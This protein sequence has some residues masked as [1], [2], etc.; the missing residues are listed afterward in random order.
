MK[1]VQRHHQQCHTTNYG[2]VT[3]APVQQNATQQQDMDDLEEC[4][5][6][7]QATLL[8]SILPSNETQGSNGFDGDMDDDFDYQPICSTV[9]PPSEDEG[10][11]V[12]PSTFD[13][14]EVIPFE[15]NDLHYQTGPTVVEPQIPVDEF[16]KHMLL[17][18]AVAAASVLV[19]QAAFQSTMPSTT[20]LPLPNIMLFLYL[21]KLVLSTGRLELSNL[22]KVLSILA[23]RASNSHTNWAPVPCTVSGFRSM[24]LNVSNSNSLVS[25]LPIPTPETLPDGHA[26]TPFSTILKHALMMNTFDPALI[27]DPKWKSIATCHKF[28]HF[29]ANIQNVETP[30]TVPFRLLA[31]GIIIWTDG[32]DTSTGCKSNRSPMYTGTITLLFVDVD[33]GEVVGCVTYPNIGGSGKINHAPVFQRLQQDILA[34]ESEGAN[35]LV[36]SRHYG[37]QVKCYTKLLF[38]VQ[39]QPERRAASCLLGGNSNVHAMFGMSCDFSCLELPFNA[40]TNCQNQVVEYLAYKDWT[41]PPR[42]APCQHCLGWSLSDLITTSYNIQSECPKLLDEQTPGYALFAGPGRLTSSMLLEG[43]NHCIDMYAVRHRWSEADVKKYLKRLCINE[44]SIVRF[45]DQCRRH[46]YLREITTHSEEYSQVDIDATMAIYATNPAG[47]DLP[48]PPPLW[49]LGEMEDKTEGIM[50]LSMG[51]QKAVFK[52]IIRWAV[53]HRL[54]TALQ[55]RL[56]THLQA[57]QVLKVAYCPCRPYKDEAFGGFTAETYRGMTMIS[58]FIYRCLLEETLKPP[59]PRG[60]NPEPQDKWTK[61]DN[62]NW[63]YLRD[64][65]FSGAI[66]ATEASAQVK[67]LLALQ[68]PPPIVNLPQ[69]PITINEIRDLVWRMFNMFRAIFCTDLCGL[70][71]KHRSTASVMRFL[72]LMETLDLKLNPKRAKPIG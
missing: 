30:G 14:D 69:E 72:S 56:E 11:N 2:S 58:C 61:Q 63:M 27:K 17:G 38:I 29:I 4:L 6:L 7:H 45:V 5:R 51:I 49:L 67:D 53:V 19:A 57:I 33:S 39:D 65:E 23:P 62:M 52:F 32:W 41:Q 35:R 31:V 47:Y 70:E 44:D 16:K 43:W 13:G 1:Q 60:P 22:A 68:T 59:P 10:W 28:Q 64:V 54:G 21:A 8:N 37:C 24:I 12:A 55:K 9:I 50:H 71:A 48:A 3:S 18:Q 25:I 26:Y 40:C 46:I 66:L 20:L 42:Q 34:F 36:A 15:D